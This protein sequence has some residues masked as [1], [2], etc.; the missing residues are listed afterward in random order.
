[1][2][3]LLEKRTSMPGGEPPDAALL[4]GTDQDLLDRLRAG[5]DGAYESLWIRH[6]TAAR[7]LA[8]RIAP[9]E[10]DDLVSE[11]FLAVYHQVKVLGRGPRTA[12]RAYL[13]TVMRNTA[14]RWRQQRHSVLNLDVDAVIEDDGARQL[15]S[16]HDARLLLDSFRALPERWQR[17]IWLSEIEGASRHVIATELGLRPNAVSALRRRAKTGLRMEWLARHVPAAIR[18]DPSHIGDVL[19][20]MV[21]GL[22]SAEERKTASAHLSACDLCRHVLEEVQS[23]RRNV[24]RTDLPVSLLGALGIAIPTASTAWAVLPTGAA[25]AALVAA[26]ATAAGSALVLVGV[27]GFGALPELPGHAL[28]TPAPQTTTVA[29]PATSPPGAAQPLVG[30]PAPPATST[31]TPTPE[32][33]PVEE[34]SPPLDFLP[35][36]PAAPYDPDTDGSRV[37]SIPT[38]ATPTTAPLPGEEPAPAVVT[39]YPSSAFLAPVLTGTVREDEALFVRVQEQPYSAVIDDEGTWSFDLRAFDLPAGDHTAE[40]WSVAASGPASAVQA[41]A[42]TIEQL[43]HDWTDEYMSLTLRESSSDGFVFAVA[44][45]PAGTVCIWSDNGQTATIPLDESGDASRRIR[46]FGYGIY[47][48]NLYPCID[49]FDGPTTYRNVSI[50]EGF[51]DPWGLDVPEW[52]LD[53]P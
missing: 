46:F 26:G 31:P 27:L 41:V 3:L 9:A 10:A 32:P 50:R 43:A 13:F 25:S 51:F 17:V 8:F 28:S 34:V 48:L 40:V 42:F 47:V 12:F 23:A 22:L 53:E 30:T 21:S 14:M 4:D 1:M 18:D 15:E 29:P 38:P 35:F 49:G 6:V 5:D 45:P 19:P 2:V 52:E 39:S 33:V 7:R 20:R 11:S 24:Q 16:E 44:G 37:R 36:D